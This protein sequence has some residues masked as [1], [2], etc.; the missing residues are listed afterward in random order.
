MISTL[1][2]SVKDVSEVTWLSK[3]CFSKELLSNL[4]KKKS[5]IFS[6]ISNPYPLGFVYIPPLIR[7]FS[8]VIPQVYGV[9]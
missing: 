4:S 5:L 8:T 7:L 9:E 3:I 6:P 1:N 2:G